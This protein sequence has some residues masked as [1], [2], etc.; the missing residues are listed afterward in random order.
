M[1]IIN[2]AI[3]PKLYVS[4][5]EVN[6]SNGDNVSDL[7]SSF[8]ERGDKILECFTET[9]GNQIISYDGIR[10]TV[11]SEERVSIN[12]LIEFA[13]AWNRTYHSSIDYPSNEPPQHH[14]F[15]SGA[16]ELILF[17]RNAGNRTWQTLK[18]LNQDIQQAEGSGAD[19]ENNANNLKEQ[20]KSNK[21]N[22]HPDK[23]EQ[24]GASGSNKNG[25][26]Q[27]NDGANGAGTSGATN[28]NAQNDQG[29]TGN[30]NSQSQRNHSSELITSVN[31]ER[32]KIIS[33]EGFRSI[34]DKLLSGKKVVVV[35]S[36]LKKL[37]T[38]WNN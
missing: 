6:D 3:H 1:L 17:T 31:E 33:F 35:I 5:T 20:E 38:D 27:G 13:E 34:R 15:V 14:M 37:A 18:S 36:D 10:V 16:G 26:V 4:N 2:N 11:S 22:N 12:H 23:G 29:K 24:G 30:A 25:N 32:D 28:Q 8:K 19:E 21:N 9:K 7:S